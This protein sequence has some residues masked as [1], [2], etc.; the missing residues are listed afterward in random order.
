MSQLDSSKDSRGAYNLIAR[1]FRVAL[2]VLVSKV[3]A[4]LKVKMLQFIR[5]N[6]ASEQ[7]CGGTNQFNMAQPNSSHHKAIHTYSYYFS[8]RHNHR[9]L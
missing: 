7:K 3:N 9:T 5:P 4:L 1:Q 6:V 2:A 8:A